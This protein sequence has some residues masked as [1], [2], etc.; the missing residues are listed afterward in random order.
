MSGV[1]G[2]CS[3]GGESYASGARGHAQVEDQALRP[4][5]DARREASAELFAPTWDS[6]VMDH[7]PTLDQPCLHLPKTELKATASTLRMADDRCPDQQ[8]SIAKFTHYPLRPSSLSTHNQDLLDVSFSAHLMRTEITKV[9]PGFPNQLQTSERRCHVI[10]K[11]SLDVSQ[12]VP[13][14]HRQIIGD[15]RYQEI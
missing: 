5:I 9:W 1:S 6:F 12:K 14:D 3:T 4:G 7:R 15:V 11:I 2:G 8:R 10:N 13:F